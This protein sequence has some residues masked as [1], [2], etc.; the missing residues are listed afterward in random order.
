M[1]ISRAV[2]ATLLACGTCGCASV[3]SG[4]SQTLTLDTVPAGADCSLM[5]KGLVIGRVNPTPGAVLVQ[6]TRD[7]I[8]VTCTRDGYQTGTFV[9]KSG[10]EAVTFGNIILG[11]LIGVAI[12][13]ASGANNKYD[14]TMRIT[15]IPG[16]PGTEQSVA[17]PAPASPQPPEPPVRFSTGPSSQRDNIRNG[18]NPP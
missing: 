8:T 5:R 16:E 14:A 7:D 3:V 18:G 17:Q 11:G 12:D 2:A 15:L 9:N 1:R 4:T 13:S 6:R 10:L